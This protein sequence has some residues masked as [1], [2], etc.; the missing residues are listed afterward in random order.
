MVLRVKQKN[1]I[2]L[3]SYAILTYG[4]EQPQSGLDRKLADDKFDKGCWCGGRGRGAF[5]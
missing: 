5:S 4:L 1:K 3:N 2:F